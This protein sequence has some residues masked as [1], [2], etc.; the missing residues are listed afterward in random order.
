MLETVAITL[1]CLVVLAPLGKARYEAHRER[2]R[3]ERKWIVEKLVYDEFALV[4]RVAEQHGLSRE[5]RAVLNRAVDF[6]DSH[7]T[8]EKGMERFDEFEPTADPEVR[9]AYAAV[10]TEAWA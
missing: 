4:R 1:L 10:L 3:Q 8:P 9:E 5:Q 7:S 2:Q 6:F